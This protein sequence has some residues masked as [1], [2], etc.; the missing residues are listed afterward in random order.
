MRGQILTRR[1]ALEIF[2]GVTGSSLAQGLAQAP[3]LPLKTTGLEHIALTVPD[4]EATAKFYGLIFNPQMFKGGGTAS[5]GFFVLTGVSYI[6]LPAVSAGVAT[7]APRIDHFCALVQDYKPDEMG[8]AL[9]DFGLS[10]ISGGYVTDP[11]GLRLQLERVPGGFFRPLQPYPRIS[12][13][14][15]AVQAIGIDH[16]MLAVSDLERSRA[17]YAKF[18]GK[19]IAHT[20]KPERIWFGA[21]KTRLGLQV[22]APGTTPAVD[23]V[24]FKIAGFDRRTVIAKLKDLRVDILPNNDEDVLRFRD[25]NGLVMEFRG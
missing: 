4:P 8:K 11:D 20:K 23:H 5:P 15:P 18:F 2:G 6:S 13:D 17:H 24:C 10:L 9:R 21:A 14:Y 7:G 22:K 12:Q 1:R 19:E 16:V 3:Q 25:L